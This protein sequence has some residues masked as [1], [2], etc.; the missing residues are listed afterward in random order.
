M[1]VLN[2]RATNIE[3]ID[4]RIGCLKKLRKLDISGTQIKKLPKELGQ[5]DNILELYAYDIDL[6]DLDFD[7]KIPVNLIRLDILYLL[8]N[9][10]I[11]Q[12]S[13]NG[14]YKPNERSHGSNLNCGFSY[15]IELLAIVRERIR[16]RHKSIELFG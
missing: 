4:S 10:T 5:L 6:E 12:R 3:Y 2:L 11:S 16:S 13:I 14:L 7:K 9:S 1:E 15:K 8:N